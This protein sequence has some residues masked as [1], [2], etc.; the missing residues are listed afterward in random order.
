MA[1]K[2]KNIENGTKIIK[3]FKKAMNKK[4]RNKK[5][6][7][8]NEGYTIDLGY[9]IPNAKRPR[10]VN[11]RECLACGNKAQFVYGD[12]RDGNNCDCTTNWERKNLKLP[13]EIWS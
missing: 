9:T 4:V 7:K 6:R 5:V 10:W 8:W 11:T 13:Q 2:I 1:I 3:D 12:R